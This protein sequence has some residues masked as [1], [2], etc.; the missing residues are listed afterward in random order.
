MDIF[1]NGKREF[2]EHAFN[3]NNKVL[4]KKEII[5]NCPIAFTNFPPTVAPCKTANNK[6]R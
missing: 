1:K 5:E 6:V 2:L 4:T 3:I